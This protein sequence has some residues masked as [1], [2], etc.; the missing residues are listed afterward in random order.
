[1]TSLFVGG[2]ELEEKCGATGLPIGPE[3]I[4]RNFAATLPALPGIHALGITPRDGIEDQERLS[5]MVG[6]P[7][8]RCE[9]CAA[10]SL[11]T[12]AAM[13]QHLGD[14]AAVGLILR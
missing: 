13:H 11:A 14:V 2:E 10:H 3:R 12:D 9:Q 6:T 7:L 4:L 1:M 5:G 8:G